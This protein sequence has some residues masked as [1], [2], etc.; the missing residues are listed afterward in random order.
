MRLAERAR[1]EDAGGRRRQV[2]AGL[3]GWMLVL[4]VEIGRRPGAVAVA[5]AVRIAF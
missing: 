5:A 2:V 1:G 4:R 3:E